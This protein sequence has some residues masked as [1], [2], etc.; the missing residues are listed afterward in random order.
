MNI[1]RILAFSALLLL[2]PLVSPAKNGDPIDSLTAILPGLPED[3]AK[4][5]ALN[6]V[7][8]LLLDAGRYNMALNNAIEARALS[9]RISYNKGMAVSLRRIASVFWGSSDY[10]KAIQNFYDA[11]EV[12]QRIAD[13]SG[14]FFC[15]NNIGL[16]YCDQGNY[17]SALPLF[18][19]G[20]SSGIDPAFSYNNLGEA[21]SGVGN[22]SMALQFFVKSLKE[23]QAKSD[24]KQIAVA[25]NNIGNMHEKNQVYDLAI[26]WYKRALDIR[27][28]MK[29]A[30]S[31]CFI[32]GSLGDVYFKKGE[33][34]TALCYEL[35]SLELAK[36]I[37]A[38]RMVQDDEKTIS[39]IY[40]RIGE[41][42]KAI[43]HHRLYVQAKDSL[44]NEENTKQ[45]VRAEMNFQFEKQQELQRRDQE[46][47]Q[48][49]Q[50][51]R[52]GRQQ[53]LRN[54]SIAG[55]LIV[56]V[57]SFFLY[58]SYQATKKAKEVIAHQHKEITDNVNYA[59]KI[60]RA[61][62]PSDQ[63]IQNA[64][65]DSFVIYKPK[66]I[67]SGDFYWSYRDS[68]Y[69]YFAT[70]DCTGHGISG[71]MMSM[72]GIAL[73]N[74]IV[75]GK[76]IKSPDLI[77]NQLREQ[78]INAINREDA[79]EERKDG[80]DISLCRVSLKNNLLEC[81]CA[82]N[83][84]FIVRGSQIIEIKANR[85]PVG[86]YVTN[87]PFD[88]QTVQL[89]KGDLVYTLSDGLP[90]QFGGPK[91]K[92]LMIKLFKE[93]ICE[94]NALSLSEIRDTIESRFKTWV[95]SGEQIDDVTVFAVRI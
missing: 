9:D 90:D 60:Q 79:N 2:L 35:K 64:I 45:T 23:A 47:M 5:D 91:G 36:Q 80:M 71:A 85:F 67:V 68:E 56:I 70:S 33:Y 14:A 94:L 24:K 86:K 61:M 58:K 74:E 27:E 19:K 7:S 50:K 10:P 8:K 72:I 69:A 83:P 63:Y 42:M 17:E 34:Q 15:M 22:N 75:V 40:E 29:D 65:P 66:D 25:M 43:A 84:V 93:W 39:E 48:Q 20:L 30:E 82:N 38:L 78:V 88:L 28:K 54:V 92:K 11:L 12:S 76:G 32:N 95:G 18:Y 1:L 13:S 26:D 31:I 41:G 46:R 51:Q 21:Y 59:Q 3:S 6:E 52:L 4:V 89:E 57:F 77:L 55:F 73:L 62:I 81:A 16:L 37:G 87:T 44:F 53:L 49:E